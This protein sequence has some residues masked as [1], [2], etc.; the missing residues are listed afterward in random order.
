MLEKINI[1]DILSAARLECLRGMENAHSYGGR[2]A[3]YYTHCGEIEMAFNLGLL[4]QERFDELNR[5]WHE[6]QP[7]A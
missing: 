2:S 1:E 3:W 4:T 6:H 5:Q 7:T